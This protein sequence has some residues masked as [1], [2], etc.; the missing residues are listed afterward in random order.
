MVLKVLIF[1]VSGIGLLNK[2]LIFEH[3][4]IH[5]TFR[6]DAFVPILFYCR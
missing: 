6:I 5:I 1:L 4:Q 3:L 2:M